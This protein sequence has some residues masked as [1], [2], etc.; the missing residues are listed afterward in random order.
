MDDP[1]F[2]QDC[3][4]ILKV[5]AMSDPSWLRRPIMLG[6]ALDMRDANRRCADDEVFAARCDRVIEEIAQII[7]AEMKFQQ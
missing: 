5:A 6:I 7:A 2:T 4:E 1:R 3:T